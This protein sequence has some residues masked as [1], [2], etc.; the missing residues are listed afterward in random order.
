MTIAG[1]PA[2]GVPLA[3]AAGCLGAAIQP[4]PISLRIGAL[5]GRARHLPK[6][7]HIL[8]DSMKTDDKRLKTAQEAKAVPKVC[9]SLC[10][11]ADQYPSRPHETG[12]HL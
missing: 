1:E 2:I 12:R 8:G 5:C 11:K 4:A 6:G 7:I 3:L 9:N 10:G